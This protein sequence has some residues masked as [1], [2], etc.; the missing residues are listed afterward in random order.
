LETAFS[1]N[2]IFT[3]NPLEKGKQKATEATLSYSSNG[4]LTEH[5]LF[6][7]VDEEYGRVIGTDYTSYAVVYHCGPDENIG[8][9]LDG[10]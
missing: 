1:K 7:F 6:G 9:F 4:V 10:V 5:H 3:W 2:K 8:T